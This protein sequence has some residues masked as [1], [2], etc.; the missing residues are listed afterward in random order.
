MERKLSEKEKSQ[1]DKLVK[2]V[3][4]ISI[5]PNKLIDEHNLYE[6]KYLSGLRNSTTGRLNR[7][8]ET[9]YEGVSHESVNL[10]V[11]MLCMCRCVIPLF[12]A[13][14][15]HKRIVNV[16]EKVNFKETEKLIRK[17]FHVP[18]SIPLVYK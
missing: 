7:L 2:T 1:L 17:E 12:E 10:D 11:K 5:R 18:D 3:R 13:S 4:Q 8:K 15:Q 14:L 16:K 9:G 6:L